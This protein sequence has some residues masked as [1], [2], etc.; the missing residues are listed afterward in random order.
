MRQW[1]DTCRPGSNVP[2][3]IILHRCINGDK[4]VKLG[5]SSCG[6]SCGVFND[7]VKGKAAKDSEHFIVTSI[8]IASMSILRLSLSCMCKLSE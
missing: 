1:P 3:V 5:R 2:D 4:E 8:Q 6:C 7:I